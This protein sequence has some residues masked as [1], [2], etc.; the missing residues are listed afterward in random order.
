M[1]NR[2]REIVW[3]FIFFG[4]TLLWMWA[5]KMAGLHDENIEL[6]AVVTNFFFIPAVLIYVFAILDRRKHTAGR[7]FTYLQGFISGCIVTLV[8]SLLSPLAQ[9]LTSVHIT[10]DYFDNASAYA[11]EQGMMTMEEAESHF[12]LTNY[13]VLTSIFTPVM[14]LV[15]S[16]VVAIFTRRKG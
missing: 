15:T 9:Y 11:V 13:I 1:K 16:A 10:P 4:V 7:Q 8:V 12:S 2:M 6:H 3:G 5:E 14:G